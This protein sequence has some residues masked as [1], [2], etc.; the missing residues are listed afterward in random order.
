MEVRFL[1]AGEGSYNTKMQKI[2]MYPEVTG[3]KWKMFSFSSYE[4]K[5]C[6]HRGVTQVPRGASSPY[7]L[8]SCNSNN[9]NQVTKPES[10]SNFSSFYYLEMRSGG[11]RRGRLPSMTNA[12]LQALKP[13]LVTWGIKISF[14]FNF[15]LSRLLFP[16]FYSL[17]QRRI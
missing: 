9:N 1:N 11:G 17:S 13:Y 3:L 4:S 16:F 14:W 5:K 7:R 8:L 10:S 6:G 15:F 2:I 12:V